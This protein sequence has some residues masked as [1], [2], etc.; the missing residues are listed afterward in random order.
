MISISPSS[1]AQEYLN[2]QSGQNLARK[3]CVSDQTIYNI[4]KKHKIKTRI[5]IQWLRTKLLNENAFDT[6]QESSAY[7]IGFLMADGNVSECDGRSPALQLGIQ[8]V[9]IDHLKNF[10]KFLSSTHKIHVDNKHICHLSIRSRRLVH[11]LQQYGIVP[12]KSLTAKVVGLESNRHFWRGVVDGDGTMG[13][14]KVKSS[15]NSIPTIALYGSE[16]LLTQFVSFIKN[17]I[18]RYAGSARPLGNI[19]VVRTTGPIAVEIIHHLY[20]DCQTTLHRK[21]TVAK[22]IINSYNRTT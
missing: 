21:M 15:P 6:I 12:R 13:S 18:P 17:I 22:S 16:N 7:W 19:F 9:D 2:G 4:L 14:Y 5:P 20:R 1:V 11:T 3:Y 8:M 10:R